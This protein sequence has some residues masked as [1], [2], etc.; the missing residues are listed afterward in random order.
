MPA[1]LAGAR[2]LVTR[3]AH[4]AD[5]FCRSV[6]QA[7][8]V[9]IRFPT[10]EI[11]AV[12]DLSSV[13]RQLAN[14]EK[15]DYAIF[16]SSNAVER[17]FALLQ[18]NRLPS[19][20]K[21]VAV[22]GKTALALERRGQPA[23]I[24]PTS[25]FTS[26][27]LLACPEMKSLRGKR[28][29]IFRGEGGRELLADT[30]RERGARVEY[31]EVYR[32]RPCSYKKTQIRKL[33]GKTA[34]SVIAITSA[35]ALDNLVMIF[36]RVDEGYLCG[37]PLIVGSARIVDAVKRFGFKQPPVVADDPSDE[38]MLRALLCWAA[39]RTDPDN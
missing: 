12:Q 30:L 32:R 13:L 11:C 38:A 33:L 18:A 35:E 10:I 28:V 25:G 22:G 26:E 1:L 31:A 27:S 19:S 7:G 24:V 15:L 29:I 20:L 14:L 2:V 37:I 8:G 3:P 6:E 4:Q 21:R 16:V 17:V 23:D 34:V 39:S 5:S 36:D 9:A